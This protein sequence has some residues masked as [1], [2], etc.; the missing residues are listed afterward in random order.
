MTVT[1]HWIF[2]ILDQWIAGVG[3]AVAQFRLSLQPWQVA[4]PPSRRMF[5]YVQDAYNRAAANVGAACSR[6]TRTFLAIYPRIH[7]STNPEPGPELSP[8]FPIDGGTVPH[9]KTPR[10][11]QKPLIFHCFCGAKHGK[12]RT[13]PFERPKFGFFHKKSQKISK[14]STFGLTGWTLRVLCAFSGIRCSAFDVRCSMFSGY[15]VWAS[16][17]APPAYSNALP[18]K[19][20]PAVPSSISNLPSATPF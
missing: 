5:N 4:L 11:F 9:Q 3:N 6:A 8:T 12:K 14:N 16:V 15:L 20:I 2:G 17:V 19:T 7:Q 1:R 10:H 13:V 18:T